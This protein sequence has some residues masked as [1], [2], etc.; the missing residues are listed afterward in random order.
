LVELTLSDELT[1]AVLTTPIQGLIGAE[2]GVDSSGEDPAPF[3]CL[4]GLSSVGRGVQSMYGFYDADGNQIY[5]DADRIVDAG[6]N[7]NGSWRKWDSGLL[8]MWHSITVSSATFAAS[9]NVFYYIINGVTFPVTS[10]TVPYVFP[11]VN[12]AA[13]AS[14]STNGRTVSGLI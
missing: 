11:S 9:M 4:G 7:A 6:S 1:S 2:Y 12:M 14:A 5:S 10:L 8:E 13:L 3:L